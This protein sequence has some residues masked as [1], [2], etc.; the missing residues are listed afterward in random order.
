MTAL[1]DD[2]AVRSRTEDYEWRTFPRGGERAEAHAY[3]RVQLGTTAFFLTPWCEEGSPVPLRHDQPAIGS[4][5]VD[6]GGRIAYCESCTIRW[7]VAV[8]EA[9]NA[10][11]RTAR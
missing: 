5:A 9:A 4:S 2:P 7:N 1:Q 3:P 6:A 10:T 8:L 11:A